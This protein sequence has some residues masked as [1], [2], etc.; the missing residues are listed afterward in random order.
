MTDLVE[1]SPGDLITSARANLVKDYIQDGTHKL[2]TLSVDVGGVE[3]IDSSRNV[4]GVDVSALKDISNYADSPMVVTGGAISEGTNAGT[5]KVAALTALFRSTDSVTSPLVYASL[6][7]QDNQTITAAD[8][9]YIVVLSYNGGSPTISISESKS[10]D[11]RN[12]PIGKV[13]KDGSNNVHFISGGFNLQDGVRKLHERAKTLR[14]L[15]LNGGSVIAYSGTNNFTM[16]EGIAYGGINKFTMPAYDSA[17]TTFIPVYGDGGA[18]FTEGTPRNTIDYAHYDDGDGTLGNVGTAKYG[19]HWVYRH[20]DDG[21]VYV[22]YGHGSYSLAEAEIEDEPPKPDHLSD[23][24][25][26]V[27]KIVAPQAGG[28]FSAIQMVTDTFFVGT[29]VSD[30]AELGNLQGGAV[31]EYNHLTDAQLSALHPAVTLGTASGLSLSTQEL[32][33]AVA[34]TDTTGALSDTDWDT[35]NGKLDDVVEDTTP[36]LGGEMDCG[37]HSIGFTQQSTT[38]DGTTTIDWKL[39]NKFKF[40]FGA[41]NETFTFTAPTNPGNFLLVLIQDGTGSRTAT[42]PGTVKWVGGTAPTLSTA[43]SS[44][45]IASFYWDGTNYFGVASL[46]FAVPA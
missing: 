30:H 43:G 38:G 22:V 33:L 46:A 21:D 35:F 41:M 39:G 23:F 1:V 5:F 16:T 7:E 42:W 10:T 9:T 31:G 29:A 20:I 40:T 11:E 3:I 17:S 12:F 45:D 27:G 8:T 2:N 32:S 34:D 18:G 26:L 19:T 36:E 6:A 4:D 14:N 37:A 28:S 13:M 25:I 44:I 15:E 24:G